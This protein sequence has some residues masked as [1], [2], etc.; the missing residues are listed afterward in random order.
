MA[1]DRD[2]ERLFEGLRRQ[3]EASA[4]RFRDVLAGRIVSG[5]RVALRL[6]VLRLAAV[7]V[8]LGVASVMAVRFVR[9]APEQALPEK[10]TPIAAWSS[11]TAW[12]LETPGRELLTEVPSLL[13]SPPESSS[14]KT[15]GMRNPTPLRKGDRS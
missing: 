2:L 9:R 5:P 7:V 8:L 4:P 12:L 15:D 14:E 11:P 1:E 6:P 13:D 3:D 10:E